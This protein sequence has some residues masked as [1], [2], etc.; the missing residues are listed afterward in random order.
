[1]HVH[2]FEGYSE[3]PLVRTEHSVYFPHLLVYS[4]EYS[5]SSYGEFQCS[6]LRWACYNALSLE[7]LQIGE[8][9]M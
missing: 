8:K 6:S 2:Y 7:R 5:A 1:M 9:C 4:R 3:P